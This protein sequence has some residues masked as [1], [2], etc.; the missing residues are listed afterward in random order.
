MKRK[1]FFF[2]DSSFWRYKRRRSHKKKTL[3]I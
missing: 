1:R 2:V 3:C